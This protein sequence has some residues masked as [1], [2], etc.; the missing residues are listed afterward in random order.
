[1]QSMAETSV[2]SPAATVL[3][4]DLLDTERAGSAA[5]RGGATRV[6][7]YGLAILLSV[8]SSALLF[9]HLGVVDSGRYVTIIALVTLA[10]GITDAGLSAIGVREL[11]TRDATGRATLMRSLSGLRLALTFLGIAAAALFALI[12]GYADTLVVGTLIAGVGLALQ[13][14]QDTYAITLTA[15]LR[16]SWVAAADLVRQTVMV[17]AIVALVLAGASL[18]P[19]YAAAI[20]AGAAA[21]GLTAWLVRGDVPLLPS[22]HIGHWR[23]LLRETLAYA[24]ATVVAAIYFRVAILIVSLIA[25]GRQT[26]YFGVSFRVIEVL[27][28]VP[29]LLVGATFPIFARAARDDRARLNYALGRTFDACLILGAGVGLA[30]LVG[31]PLI[32]GVI[33]GPK[34]HPAEAVLRIQGLALVASFTGAVWGYALL[35]L[36]RHRAVFICSLT[37]L[38]LTVILTA[39]LTTS[40]GARGAAIAT[41]IAEALFSLMLGV[42]VFRAGV[43]P[44]ISWSAAPRVLAAALL[45]AATLAI[46]G[47]ADLARVAL[48]LALYVGALLALR[49]VPRE[50]IDQ[51]PRRLR[52]LSR[53]GT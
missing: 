38:A 12:A 11:A 51:L 52:L 53:F 41:A 4:S 42:S 20:P 25:S 24:M 39:L 7:G 10:G 30:L 1:M 3:D 40:D 47:F 49:A 6:G 48:A 5:I 28:I 31:A 21:A 35:S 45:G 37:S 16:L 15:Q 14:L 27:V 43:R 23:G 19:F 36:H 18:L 44:A 13:V 32:I 46:P 8:G 17:S 50:I 9:R 22:I 26:G 34:F 29:Q 33:A 2:D